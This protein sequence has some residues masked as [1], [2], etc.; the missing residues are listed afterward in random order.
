MVSSFLYGEIPMKCLKCEHVKIVNENLIS[1]P[2]SRCVKKEGWI[3]DVRRGVNDNRVHTKGKD[4][5]SHVDRERMDKGLPVWREDKLP[6]QD[7]SVLP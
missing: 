3:A 4:T 1:C 6:E 7:M 2:Y 5:T